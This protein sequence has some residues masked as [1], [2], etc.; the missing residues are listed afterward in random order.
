MAWPVPRFDYLVQFAGASH[1][2]KVREQNEDAWRAD[3]ELGVFTVADG[4]GGHAGG[5]FAAQLSVDGVPRLLRSPD[6]ERV[7]DSFLRAPSL[8]ARADV[9]RVLAAVVRQ[10]HERLRATAAQD[11]LIEGA[12]TTLDVLLLLGA[13][14]F[15][16]HVGDGRSYLVRPATTIQLT[17]DHTVRGSLLAC[18]IGTPSQPPEG[19]SALVNALGRNTRLDVDEV[20]V[21]LAAGD[22][23]VLCT[24]GV[25]GELET[26]AELQTHAAH[27]S[28]EECA[29]G[30]V[31]AALARRGRDNATALVV[32][33]GTKRSSRSAYDG[34]LSARNFAYA[35]HCPLLL[36][37]PDQ[38]AA[39]ALQAAIEVRFAAG[40]RVPR[41]YAGDRVAYI[42]LEGAIL[43][44]EGWTLSPSALVYPESLAGG[45]RGERLC[46]AVQATRAFRIRADDFREVCDRDAQLA[47]LVY[48]R[49]ARMLARAIQ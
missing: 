9:F 18:G 31:D 3:P 21:E 44:T 23:I 38:L 27:G 19:S 13:H 6:A 35:R 17:S 7:F 46:Q 33:V 42:V 29:L 49:L 10:T 37:L 2:G 8:A 47:R 30:L 5:E 26:E 40:D 4:I 36:G 39:A 45:G 14:G 28:A 1:V 48:E 11:P 32:D 22:R 12:G 20:F 43:T 15:L 34:G 25:Y 24:D 41:V 16:A